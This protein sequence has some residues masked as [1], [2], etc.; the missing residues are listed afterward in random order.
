MNIAAYVLL[1]FVAGFQ[2]F[3]IAAPLIVRR[4]LREMLS[5][6]SD[7]M[8]VDGNGFLHEQVRSFRGDEVDFGFCH[9]GDEDSI[10][11]PED[12]K[13]EEAF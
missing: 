11:P 9:M 1:V 3:Q 2:A 12:C 6:P 7:C 4:R 5:Q 10:V 13:D 8:Y